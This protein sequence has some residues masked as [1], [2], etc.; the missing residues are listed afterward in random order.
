MNISFHST[1]LLQILFFLGF[2]STEDTIISGNF[3]LKDQ[4]LGLKWVQEN[5]KYFGG[6]PTKVTIFGESAGAASVS[7]Q[8]LNKKSEGIFQQLILNHKL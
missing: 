5:I 3:G 6:D 4:Q 1:N 2:L 8:Y 7:Y